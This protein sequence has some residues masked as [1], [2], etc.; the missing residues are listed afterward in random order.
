MN[1]IQIALVTATMLLAGTPVNADVFGRGDDHYIGLQMT[2]PLDLNHGSLFARKAEY[3]VMF[4]EQR[5]GLKEGVA[6][7]RAGDG[8]QTLGYLRPTYDFKIGQSRISN[9]AIPVAQFDG[10]GT[11]YRHYEGAEVVLAIAVGA[12]VLVKLVDHAS[13]EIVDCV[14][15]DD[16]DNIFCPDDE[17][18]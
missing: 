8:T 4:I 10:Y 16:T 13:D 1:R 12:V 11:P 7:T 3:S 5:D 6:F 14:T 2:L 9:H 18:D 17:D 15:E